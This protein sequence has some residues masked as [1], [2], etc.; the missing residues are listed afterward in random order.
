MIS[1]NQL[2]E[3]QKQHEKDLQQYG[4]DEEVTA[5]ALVRRSDHFLREYAMAHIDEI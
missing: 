5:I 1:Q 2:E 3:W 4:K